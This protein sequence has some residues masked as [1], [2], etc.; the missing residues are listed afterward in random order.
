MNRATNTFDKVEKYNQLYQSGG[1]SGHWWVDLTERFP[2][3]LVA[4]T[5]VQRAGAITRN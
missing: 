4:T 3:V 1:Y 2:P 5:T